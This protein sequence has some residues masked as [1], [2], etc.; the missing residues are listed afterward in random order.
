MVTNQASIKRNGIQDYVTLRASAAVI[1]A[2]SIFMVYFFIATP[3]ITFEIWQGL[4]ASIYMKAFTLVTLIAI[5][6]HVRIG[7]WQVLTD[8]VKP[9]RLRIVLQFVLNLLAIAYVAI[10]LFVLWGV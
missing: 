10:G 6:M 5:L 8:Y 3:V 1:S 2:F 9:H 7:L 4:F